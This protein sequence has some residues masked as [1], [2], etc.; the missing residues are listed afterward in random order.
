MISKDHPD[1]VISLA[2]KWKGVSKETDAIIKHGS[3][4]L[5]KKGHTEILS[6]YGLDGKHV[7]VLKFKILT[8][9]VKPGEDLVFSFEVLNGD[10]KKQTVRL[11]YGLYYKKSNGQWSKKVFKISERDYDAGV[12]KMVNRKQSFRKITTRIFYPGK[13]KLSIIVNGEEKTFKTFELL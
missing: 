13:H 7:Q 12:K 8:P 10:Q 1:L 11:E 3:R 5:L 6:H 4:T 2:R 9:R